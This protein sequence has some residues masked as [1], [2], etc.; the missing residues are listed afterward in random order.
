MKLDINARN[1]RR[2]EILLGT[3]NASIN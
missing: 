3:M 1:C 2:G